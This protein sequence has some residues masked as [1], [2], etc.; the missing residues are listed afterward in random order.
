[1]RLFSR[2]NYI[3]AIRCAVWCTVFGGLLF[4]CGEGVRLIPFSAPAAPDFISVWKN[5]P[6]NAYQKNFHRFEKKH[7][8]HS[9]KNQ[10]DGSHSW[11][12]GFAAADL[13]PRAVAGNLLTA[14]LPFRYQNVKA[15]LLTNSIGSRAPPFS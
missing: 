12:N 13:S 11:I 4:S 8:G 6:E 7:A 5:A 14:A 10:R 2:Q 3:F 15:R 1:M 9:L